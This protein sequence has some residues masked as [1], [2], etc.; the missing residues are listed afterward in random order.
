MTRRLSLTGQL[1]VLQLAIITV[2]VLGVVLV[3]VAQ[4][5]A[6]FRD[7]EGRRA[8]AVAETVADSALVRLG[9]QSDGSLTAL[10]ITAENYRT[11][12][13]STYIVV[14]DDDLRV[15]ASP[16]PDQLGTRLPLNGSPVL[17]GRGWIGTVDDD[18]AGRTVVAMAPVMEDERGRVGEVIGVVAV[19]HRYPSTAETLR[20]AAPT[21]LT[22]LGV[23]SL[24]GVLGSLL[25]ARRVR[26][27]TLGLD[28]Q[29]IVGLVEHRDATLHG[30]REGI[31]AL[32]LRGRVTLANDEAVE[33]LHLPP[34][35]VGRPVQELALDPDVVDTLSRTESS[36]DQV[37]PVQG[38]LLILNSLP[39]TSRGQRIGSVTTLRDRTELMALQRELD[40]TQHVTDTLRAQAHEFSNRLHTISGLIELEQY[41][42]VVQYVQRLDAGVSQFTSLV[43]ERIRDPAVAALLVAK[44]AQ[45]DERGVVLTVA[46]GTVLGHV[47]EAMSTDI[48][49]VT[50]NLIDNAFDAIATEPNLDGVQER[51]EVTVEIVEGT[52]AVTVRVR[53]TGPGVDPDHVGDLFRRGFSTKGESGERGIGLS[54]VHLVCRRR[55]G[56][57]TVH[58]EGGA[59]FVATLPSRMRVGS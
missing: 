41:G 46:P 26:R 13:G 9:T 30:I 45:A 1:L 43:V 20:L 50:G 31:I 52:D 22:Y 4:E 6:R 28:P 53:D 15:L 48:A 57:V 49:T 42:D 7:T 3:T 58:N 54:L 11:T 25:I 12:S 14:T 19:G 23:A 24:V 18:R 55:G 16:Y 56:G 27:Q 47:D 59:V 44:G 29:E 34:D 51:G 32:D 8:R 40:V 35:A 38:R 5:N 2:V 21:L 33:L 37:L 36:P 39:I 10:R 17:E